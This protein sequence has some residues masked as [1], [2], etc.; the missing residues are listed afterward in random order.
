MTEEWT[1]WI[2]HTPGPCPVQD[3]TLTEVDGFELRPSDVDWVR[4]RTA[5]VAMHNQHMWAC[6]RHPQQVIRYRIRK[7]RALQT[8]IKLAESLPEEVDA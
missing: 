7:P 5:G 2:E 8:L 3:G 6:L 1:D 4:R